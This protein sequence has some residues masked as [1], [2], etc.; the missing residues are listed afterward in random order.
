VPDA[1]SGYVVPRDR[2]PGQRPGSHRGPDVIDDDRRHIREHREVAETLQQFQLDHDQHGGSFLPGLPAHEADFRGTW[3]ERCFQLR[4]AGFCRQ[5]RIDG[6][7]DSAHA[8]G[9][10]RV[11][12]R[13]ICRVRWTSSSSK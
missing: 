8:G 11:K 12:I 3:G 2:R 13:S 7:V 5:H 4:R 9:Y 10:R 1:S 6:L